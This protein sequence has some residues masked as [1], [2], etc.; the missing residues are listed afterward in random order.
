MAIPKPIP[1]IPFTKDAFE[2]LETEYQ[3]LQKERIEIMERLKIAREMGDLSE[4]GAYKYAKF[5]LG[6]V[7]RELRR[8]KHLLDNGFINNT[9]STGSNTI[10]FG[11]TVTLTQDSNT[12]TFLLV[13]AHES[14]LTQ[15]K[16]SLESP[17]GKALI[18]KTVGDRIFVQ[19]PAG[20]LEYTILT[21]Q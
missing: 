16:L 4:N 13:S 15:N 8:I 9:H 20:T 21:I 18:G 14:D 11:T 17:L 2:K 10:E 12:L 7:S 19:A 6:N 3:R 1:T 5:E